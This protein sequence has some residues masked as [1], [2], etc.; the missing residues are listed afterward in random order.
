MDKGGN[1]SQQP[2]TLLR[3]LLWISS[4]THIWWPDT[5][6]WW[7]QLPSSGQYPP[8]NSR[9]YDFWSWGGIRWWCWDTEPKS[10]TLHGDENRLLKRETMLQR[11]II[12]QQRYLEV[13]W[14][15]PLGLCT[16]YERSAVAD[17]NVAWICKHDHTVH[18]HAA[19]TWANWK[20]TRSLLAAN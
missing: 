11:R 8:N 5:Y 17:D 12:R 13:I 9:G 14:N 7:F 18:F 10:K 4:Q 15:C 1:K 2:N 20:G 19:C 6:V 16:D 3:H